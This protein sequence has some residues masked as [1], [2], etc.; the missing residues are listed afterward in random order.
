MVKLMARK[1][2]VPSTAF[3]TEAISS[4]PCEA[5]LKMTAMMTQPMVSS[6][7]AVATMIW[8]TLRRMKFI[9][10]TTTATIF[11]EEIDSAVPMNSDATRRAC[12][13]GSNASGRNSPSAKPQAKG[14]RMPAI[15]I[16]IAALPTFLTSLRSVSMPVSSSSRRI[17]NWAMPS[18]I[19][20][21]SGVLGKIACCASGQIQ[22]NSDGPSRMPA[23]NSPI[24]EGWPMRCMVSPRPRPTAIKST[25]C[26][27]SRNSDGP[28]DL[29]PSAA[30]A[31]VVRTRAAGTRPTGRSRLQCMQ[32]SSPF[33][34]PGK[35]PDGG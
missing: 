23:S 5:R 14:T 16:A 6:M 21:C 3:A 18:I 28:A 8:P 1:A 4:V 22:P 31:M 7:T 24:T 27:T 34:C 29:P 9:S 30:A 15:E 35:V 10:R 20:F 32:V 12:G 26:A 33:I 11:T 2:S 25:I 19:A 13:F 17:P